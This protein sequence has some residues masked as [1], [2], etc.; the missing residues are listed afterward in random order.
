MAS[1]I[2]NWSIAH[3]RLRWDRKQPFFS[4]D[5]TIVDWKSYIAIMEY[6]YWA[7]VRSLYIY[8]FGYNGQL[9]PRPFFRHWDPDLPNN[10]RPTNKVM[11]GQPC[12]ASP[13]NQATRLAAQ[14]KK[15]G[16]QS[17]TGL[18][19]GPNGHRFYFKFL[20]PLWPGGC[21]YPNP[22]FHQGTTR[23]MTSQQTRIPLHPHPRLNYIAH[24]PADA[25]ST[26]CGHSQWLGWPT[27]N[28]GIS[29][30]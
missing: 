15:E 29:A 10:G 8:G 9:W 21:F 26:V 19:V 23:A 7:G 17:H 30:P 22:I 27:T 5:I 16:H 18:A 14:A 11:K 3:R 24:T 28:D 20:F 2:W 6:R 4:Q 13:P 12:Q 1:F 25:L